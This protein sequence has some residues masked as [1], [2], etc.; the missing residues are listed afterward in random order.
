MRSLSFAALLCASAALAQPA[1]TPEFTRSAEL[2]LEG[3]GA[4]YSL[5][6][7]IEVY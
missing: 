7:P 3:K 4:I 2:T 1:S 6:L 5:E